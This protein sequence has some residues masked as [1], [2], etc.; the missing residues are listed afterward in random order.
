MSFSTILFTEKGRALQSKVL[1]GAALN[2]TRIGMG[3]GSLGGQSQIALNNLIDQKVSL[4]VT[5]VSKSGSYA[6][7][8]GNFRNADIST[9]FY[10]RE[11]G[12]FAQDPDIG[13]ILYCYGNAGSLAE[14]IP[15]QSSEIVEKVV[16]LSVIVGDTANVTLLTDSTA[17]ATK[18][19]VKAAKDKADQAFRSASNGKEAIK[20]AIT[21][22]DP[23]VTIP[24][25]ATFAQ[26][27]TAIGQIETGVDTEDATAIAEGLLE[28]LSAYVK[29]LKIIGTMPNK[30]GHTLNARD[31]IN[32]PASGKVGLQFPDIIGDYNLYAVSPDTEIE[33]S[34]GLLSDKLG[35][36]AADIR[37]GAQILNRTGTFSSD[38]TAGAGS[39]LDGRIAYTNGNKV[40]GTI[41][42]VN[43]DISGQLPASS[44]I[45]G[46]SSG[47]GLNYLYMQHG[48]SGKYS[49]GVNWVRS[50]QPDLIAAN[51][52]SGKNICGMVGTAIAGKRYATGQV[53]SGENVSWYSPEQG[54]PFLG[55]K[56]HVSQMNLSFVPSIV[57]LMATS[58]SW[59][60]YT[61][62]YFRQGFYSSSYGVY[63]CKSESNSGDARQPLRPASGDINEIITTNF[64]YG[65]PFTF[66]AWE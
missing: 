22:I 66:W 32:L 23:T 24:T 30:D 5:Q 39:I 31:V 55:R 34:Y 56:V 16:G 35:I 18:A 46:A 17:F 52:L 25:E 11:L 45:V 10:W 61:T 47:D 59:G 26:L 13:E 15:P 6:V 54:G 51:I 64:Q 1:A 19:E 60:A 20:T 28:N 38:A 12:I 8:E 9:G 44:V 27:A 57:L 36:K 50:Y 37:A 53:T 40:T 7:V 33:V 65:S 2:F 43:P 63:T 48:L 42:I 21:G 62:I 58:N 49:N 4:N 14:Y 3:S 29:G 41:P